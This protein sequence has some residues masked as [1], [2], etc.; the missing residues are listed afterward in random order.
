MDRPGWFDNK[1]VCDV[2]IGRL[3]L[4]MH[5]TTLGRDFCSKLRTSDESALGLSNF[6]A[7][8][9]SNPNP[10][11]ING[12][13]IKSKMPIF[14]SNWQGGVKNS[15][16][17]YHCKKKVKKLNSVSSS[18]FFLNAYSETLKCPNPLNNMPVD[19]L[20]LRVKGPSSVMY[21]KCCCSTDIYKGKRCFELLENVIDS[22]FV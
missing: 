11:K 8:Q 16:D 12:S 10:I 2:T 17:R 7:V 14:W 4:N 18:D 5:V 3:K 20:I 21:R 1:L 22:F 13:Q 6:K 9:M 19:V 15:I